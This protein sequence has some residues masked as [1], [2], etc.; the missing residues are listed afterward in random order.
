MF[1]TCYFYFFI[2]FLFFYFYFVVVGWLVGRMVLFHV[3][4]FVRFFKEPLK[5]LEEFP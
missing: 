4:D 1:I 2:Y 3:Y 5:T